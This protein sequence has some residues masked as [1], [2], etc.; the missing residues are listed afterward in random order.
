MKVAPTKTITL[1]SSSVS[2]SSKD[3]Y[4]AGTTYATDAEVKVSFESDGTTPLFPVVEYKSLADAN[5]GNY[6][7]DSPTQWTETGT[8]NIHAMFDGYIN[9]ATTDSTDI[10]VVVGSA[11]SDFIGLFG[12]VGTTVTLTLSRGGSAIKT[13]EINLK[14]QPSISYYAWLFEDYEYKDR[15]FWEYPKYADATLSVSIA[16][17]QGA[18]TCGEMIIGSQITL[19][20]TQYDASVGIQDYSVYSTDTLGRTY[21]NQGD[22]ADRAE[23]ELW[24]TNNMVDI[25]RRKLADVRGVM[26]LWDLNNTGSDYDSLRIYGFFESFDII[27]P[28]PSISKC[29][30]TI[31]GTT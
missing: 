19:G 18:A 7:P 10:D 12:L 2:S 21:L 26:S 11:K 15:I 16:P 14:T 4:A 28:G 3:E 13:E 30:L 1:I 23:V 20:Q 24:I 29:S 31:R 9:S 22:Y 5:T 8:S 25:V 27:I 17:A 6:P